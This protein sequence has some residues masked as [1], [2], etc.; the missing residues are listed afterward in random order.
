MADFADFKETLEQ[1]GYDVDHAIVK[2]EQFGV[3]QRRRRL[4]VLASRLLTHLGRS[5]EPYEIVC[6]VGEDLRD[7]SEPR[8]REKSVSILKEANARVMT[9]KQL[10]NNARRA[11]SEYIL[12][13]E[14]ASRVFKI[15]DA[16]DQSLL[17]D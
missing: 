17:K 7:W 6:L 15:L 16:I 4:V 9:Y 14:K 2:C 10:I 1:S 5:E 3:P 8:G 11:Y 12:A 13:S